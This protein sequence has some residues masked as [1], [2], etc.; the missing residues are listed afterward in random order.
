M[1]SGFAL[2]LTT[3]D[4]LI[5]TIFYGRACM[6]Y[7]VWEVLAMNILSEDLVLM[8]KILFVISCLDLY[9]L[10]YIVWEILI[11]RSCL[12]ILDGRYFQN[13]LVETILCVTYC[14]DDLGWTILSVRS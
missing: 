10:D 12:N 8:M 3:V 14:I 5:S 9:C 13:H 4:D 11:G 1:P 6:E 2:K 7:L